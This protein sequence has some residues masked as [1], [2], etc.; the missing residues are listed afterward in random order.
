M[1]IRLA[2]IAIVTIA[3]GFAAQLQ[4]IARSL[5][6]DDLGE[7]APGK[8]ADL[9]LLEANPLEDIHATARIWRVVKGGYLFDPRRL[10]TGP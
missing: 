7:I 4:S 2:R 9:V 6:A 5:G 8:L 3:A 1:R 10:Q